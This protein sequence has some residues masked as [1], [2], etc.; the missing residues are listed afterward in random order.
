MHR[1]TFL[2]S[3]YSISIGFTKFSITNPATLLFYRNLCTFS[4]L[5]WIKSAL[6]M[7][8]GSGK[9]WK[10]GRHS[11]KPF[12]KGSQHQGTTLTQLL[13]Q[14]KWQF[15]VLRSTLLQRLE[16]QQLWGCT[17]PERY[18]RGR[19][20]DTETS[21]TR[22]RVPTRVCLISYKFAEPRFV[23]QGGLC[24]AGQAL[25][26][27]SA[28]AWEPWTSG[29]RTSR[30]LMHYFIDGH[31]IYPSAPAWAGTVHPSRS[32]L[33]R[34]LGTD[35]LWMCVGVNSIFDSFGTSTKFRVISSCFASTMRCTPG[36]VSEPGGWSC[37]LGRLAQMPCTPHS[38]G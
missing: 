15:A 30:D 26:L 36:N 1:I 28:Y 11:S 8:G 33:P 10:A 20:L 32:K 4:K 7:S 27:C 2:S 35:R 12:S 9:S 31:R 23:F 14:S 37:L 38:N 24:F 16:H 6:L 22:L 21:P 34:V 5:L 19:T 3:T 25:Q 18:I 13:L 17:G 29:T